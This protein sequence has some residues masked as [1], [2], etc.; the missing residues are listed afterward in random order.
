MEYLLSVNFLSHPFKRFSVTFNFVQRIQAC[1]S[2]P[3]AEK[4]QASAI[5]APPIPLQEATPSPSSVL[6]PPGATLR[7]PGSKSLNLGLSLDESTSGIFI[8]FP[9]CLDSLWFIVS[10][11]L[12]SSPSV[13]LPLLL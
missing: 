12:L 5:L 7:P 3:S 13:L 11:P 1:S 8:D 6:R 4:P 10:F 2:N 9:F